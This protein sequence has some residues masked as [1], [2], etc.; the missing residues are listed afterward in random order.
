MESRLLSHQTQFLHCIHQYDMAGGDNEFVDGLRVGSIIRADHPREWET[1]TTT[2][3]DFWDVGQEETCG[4]F[5][6]ASSLPIF[7]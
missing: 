7:Q 3:V 4:R 2:C 6:K 5:H 1:L